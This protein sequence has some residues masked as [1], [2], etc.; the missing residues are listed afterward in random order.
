MHQIQLK[1]KENWQWEWKHVSEWFVSKIP[2]FTE[3]TTL[4]LYMQRAYAV[5][6]KIEGKYGLK[7]QPGSG[8]YA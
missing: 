1:G 4:S 8:D 5:F 7:H 2:L 6:L 3:L